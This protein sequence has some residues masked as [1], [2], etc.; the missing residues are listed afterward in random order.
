[1]ASV[2]AYVPPANITLAL[3]LTPKE[4]QVLKGYMQNELCADEDPVM[5]DIRQA[6]WDALSTV[7]VPA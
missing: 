2:K 7:N 6:I 5:Q 3:E 4:A 1:M